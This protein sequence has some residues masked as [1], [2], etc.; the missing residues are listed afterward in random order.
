MKTDTVLERLRHWKIKELQFDPFGFCN[1]KCWFCPVA[2]KPNPESGKKQMPVS[3]ME[4]IFNQIIEERR[5]DGIVAQTFNGCYTGH[6]NEILLYR[7]F[8]EFLETLRKHKLK[9]MV[10]TNGMNLIKSRVD[11]IDTYRDVVNGI[12]INAPCFE[13]VLF[14]ERT[15]FNP[16]KLDNLVENIR[17]AWDQ[18]KWLGKSFSIQINGVERNSFYSKGGWLDDS[19][20]PDIRTMTNTQELE[21]QYQTAKSLFPEISIFKMPSLI[22]R[23]GHLQQLGII[24]NKDAIKQYLQ[25]DKTEVVACS[26]GLQVGGRPFGWLHINANA[27]TFLCCND[28]DFDHVFGNLREN[29]L[30]EVW[31]SEKHAQMIQN[32]FDT[33]CR[34]CASSLWG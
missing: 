9:T 31:L 34:S 29:T 11:L 7:Y 32:A 21:L 6:Y 23:A 33:I 27:D 15:G 5:P 16:D 25:K 8:P 17:Y 13:K 4:D 3:V 19:R 10:L 14:K 1:A 26:N 18:L 28:Y 2:Y 12:C 20:S 22:D 30:R 24:S